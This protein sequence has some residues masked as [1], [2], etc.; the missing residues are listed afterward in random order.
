M[1][2]VEILKKLTG[3]YGVSGRESDGIA[4]RS[5]ELLSEYGEV[6]VSPL[7]SVSVHIKGK[8]K[9]IL[10]DAHMDSIGMV[11]TD[12][13]SS[14]FLRI[15]RCGGVDTRILAAAPVTVIGRKPLKGVIISTPPHLAKDGDSDK[16]L[17]FENAAV[18]TGLSY[19]EA[20]QLIS[21]GDRIVFD[22]EFLTLANGR[23]CCPYLDDRAG[24]AVLINVLD[25]LRTKKT[26]CDITVQFAVQEE[27]GGSGANTGAFASDFDEAIAVDVSFAK[28]PSVT[29]PTCGTLGKGSMICISPSL[30]CEFSDELIGLAKKNGIPYQL[31][32]CPG[33]TGTDADSIAAAKG[34]IKTAV[35]SVPQRNMHTPAEIV[36]VND[37]GNTSRLIADYILSKGENGNDK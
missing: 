25:I 27:T 15:D 1:Q 5:A 8:G 21:V 17:T 36:D 13:D 14:G 26:D 32:V 33:L 12:V 3:C 31:E 23:V 37:I 30:S 29:E 16:A 9:R 18:D 22:G 6:T 34:G 24:M 35:I 7:G 20:S 19:E 11:V 10:L 28:A 4:D 2:T